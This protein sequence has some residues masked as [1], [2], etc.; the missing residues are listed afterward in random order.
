[1][2]I[3]NG[4]FYKHATQVK[5]YKLSLA[6]FDWQQSWFINLQSQLIGFN[7]LKN[8]PINMPDYSSSSFGIS[9]LFRQEQTF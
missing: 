5:H 3:S 7:F 8:L 1:M 2:G 4:R 9:Y 6:T